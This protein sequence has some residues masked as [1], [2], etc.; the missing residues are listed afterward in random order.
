[1]QDDDNQDSQTTQ[2]RNKS[3]G[4]GPRQ[5]AN[6]AGSQHRSSTASSL[7][8]RILGDVS[9][10][11]ENDG[12]EAG[13]R[14]EYGVRRPG[15]SGGG[16]AGRQSRRNVCDYD[17][18]HENSHHDE[19][20]RDHD[21][22]DEDGDTSRSKRGHGPKGYQRSDERLAEIV[23]GALYDDDILD[24]SGIEVSVT[25]GDVRL[26]GT[27]GSRRHKHRAENLAARVSCLHDVNNGL[28]V[29]RDEG[30]A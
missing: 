13:D 26:N 10:W 30:E 29:M 7:F 5:G 3:E 27:V 1:M 24:A 18:S 8:E 19:L 6:R 16:N 23:N 4:S 21:Y 9:T 17:A 11:L 15:T 14:R 22:D 2:E 28:R 25:D 12:A 20:H